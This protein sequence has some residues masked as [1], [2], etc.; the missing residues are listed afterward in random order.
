M[1]HLTWDI[2]RQNNEAV[3]TATQGT[4]ILLTMA[5]RERAERGAALP[6]FDDVEF[7]VYSQNG[8]DGILLHLFSLLGSPTKKAVEICAGGG[9]ECNAANLII[10]RGWRGL[11]V[12]GDKIQIDRC[13]NFYLG[14]SNTSWYPP[15]IVEAWVTTDNVN[16]LIQ[17]HGFAGEIDL[18]SLDLDGIDYW[19]WKAIGCIQPRVIVAE[20]NWTWGPEASMTVPYD[21]EFA[22]SPRGGGS[23][24][25]NIYFGASLNALVK[26]A[27][28]K[29]YRLVGCERW[30]F[31][32]FFVRES[33]GEE[34]F[35]EISPFECF[36]SPVMRM[37]WNPEF[38]NEHQSREWI[39]V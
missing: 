12:D 22:L 37:R 6:S 5:Y 26:L 19:I 17:E 32:A 34:Y 36:E 8:E 25:D 3:A 38:L 14:G 11:L 33:I 1:R 2:V 35:P 13:R 23:W 10:N 18:L 29:G 15:H 9:I 39:S 7:K 27:R 21:P 4:Q 28:E 30:G 20:Y 16:E 24:S 31:N